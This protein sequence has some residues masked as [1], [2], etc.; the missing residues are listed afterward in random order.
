MKTRLG[1][2]V[3]T[4]ALAA[5]V[6]ACGGGEDAGP[7]GP[8]KLSQKQV[9]A[10]ASDSVLRISGKQAGGTVWGSAVLIDA[11]KRLAITASHVVTATDGLVAKLGDQGRVP[12]E[13]VGN[14]PCADLA[15]VKLGRDLPGMRAVEF[16]NS[17]R[18]KNGDVNYVAG[19]PG[20]ASRSRSLTLTTTRG[21]VTN[22][23]VTDVAIGV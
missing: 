11:R 15:V 9:I 7:T 17:R 5:G 20:T 6:A 22:A 1:A 14:N 10:R 8:E 23:E 16:G 18:L 13:V 3:A 19:Y 2:I 21:M 4:V 12:V